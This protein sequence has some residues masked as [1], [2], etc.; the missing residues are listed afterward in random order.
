PFG[1]NRDP[2]PNRVWPPATE[3]NRIAPPALL[4]VRIRLLTSSAG[5]RASSAADSQAFYPTNIV[6]PL[7]H[8][9]PQVFASARETRKAGRAAQ[10]T[11]NGLGCSVTA[12]NSAQAAE[13]RR[14]LPQ[15]VW[16]KRT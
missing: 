8:R 1:P 7:Q 3:A 4:S 15:T 13:R 11:G 16:C 5:P 14:R 12:R 9:Q 6:K 2:A 10:R